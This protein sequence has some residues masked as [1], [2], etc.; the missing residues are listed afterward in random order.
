MYH[1][2]LRKRVLDLE[3]REVVE[4]GLWEIFGM[5]FKQLPDTGRESRKRLEGV[6]RRQVGGDTEGYHKGCDARA[7][8]K[9][10]WYYDLRLGRE[11][12]FDAQNFDM[13]VEE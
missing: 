2:G 4:H 8:R 9:N 3:V 5:I 11:Y 6:Q 13:E 12:S 1:L 10:L 7:C